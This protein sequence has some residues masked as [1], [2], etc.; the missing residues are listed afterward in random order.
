V[1]YPT[2]S[3]F[4]RAL[5]ERAKQAARAGSKTSGQLLQHFYLAQ[6][7]RRVFQHDP[8]GWV[9]K[10][11]QALLVRYPD[12]RYSRDVDLI[13]AAGVAPDLDE[14]VTALRQ[15]AGL[16]LGDHMRFEYRDATRPGDER[17]A[18]TARFDVYIGTAEMTVLSIDIVVDHR[19]S[20][21]P[22]T[23][24]LPVV[25][26]VR[27]IAPGP[28][29]KLYPIVDQVADKICAMIERHGSQGAVSSRYRDLVDLVM[30][31]LA[32][33]IDGAEQYSVLHAEVL[34]RQ[35]AGT[36]ITLPGA[37]QVP[38]PDTW[39]NGYA[40]QAAEVPN[41][42]EF[43]TLGPAAEL[44]SRFIDPLL[45]PEAPMKWQPSSREWTK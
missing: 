29:I 13:Y 20:K 1:T 44:A 30:I 28:T 10:G 26:P 12:A 43:T 31:I 5:T 19:P 34:R 42:D 21:A 32:E 22:V 35:K 7:L 41:F 38:D 40:R 17:S 6:L 14:A 16:D 4:R 15:A 11:G 25:L 36:Q 24:E 33:Q 45:G 18:R 2:P 23:C 27:G 3:A 9:L 39:E 37:F 8:D